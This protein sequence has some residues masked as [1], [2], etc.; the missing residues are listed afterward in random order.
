MDVSQPAMKSISFNTSELFIAVVNSFYS[1]AAPLFFPSPPPF[2]TPQSQEPLA[3]CLAL[4][5]EHVGSF[6]HVPPKV[7]GLCH[8]IT[9]PCRQ[10][11]C[12][13]SRGWLGDGRTDTQVGGKQTSLM[14]KKQQ[15]SKGKDTSRGPSVFLP[16]PFTG[17]AFPHQMQDQ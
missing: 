10:V 15:I 4:P 7:R 6:C 14:K 2:S 12:P 17:Q 3:H 9:H 13:E 1:S 5:G 16:L 8:I 11:G